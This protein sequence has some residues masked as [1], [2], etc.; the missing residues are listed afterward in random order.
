MPGSKRSL[1]QRFDPNPRRA[2]PCGLA[3]L[4]EGFAIPRGRGLPSLGNQ[5]EPEPV[6]G[7][8]RPYSRGASG[9]AIAHMANPER[10]LKALKADISA[11][12]TVGPTASRRKLWSELAGKAGYIDP[13]SL[14]P[15][16][17]FKVMG[18]LKLAGFRSAQLYLDAAK[19]QHIALGHQWTAQ[20]QQAYRSSVRSCARHIGAP[21]QASPLPLLQLAAFKEKE[22]I[23]KGGPL[24][25]GRSTILA[26]WWLLREIEASHATVD[27]ILVEEEL[28]RISWRLPCSKTDWK[29]L[30]AVRQHSCSCEFA[31]PGI[32]PYH[33]M[34]DHLKDIG[35]GRGDTLFPSEGGAPATKQGWADTFQELAV[36]LN[37]DPLHANGARRFT[38]HSARATGAVH[39]ASTQVELWRVQLFGRWG[40]EVFLHYIRDAPV[41]QLDKLALETSVHLSLESAKKQLQDLLRKKERD[42]KSVVA[43]PTPDMMVDCEAAA[44]HIDPPRQS[45]LAVRNLN[46]GK[47]KFIELSHMGKISTQKSGEHGVRGISATPTP[48]TSSSRS[49]KMDTSAARNASPSSNFDPMTPN[50]FRHLRMSRTPPQTPPPNNPLRRWAKFGIGWGSGCKGDRKLCSTM[51]VQVKLG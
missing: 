43:C 28:K 37:L 47:K 1:A 8:L 51:G 46:G 26:S 42:L 40:S 23:A 27:H 7:G 32:C 39:L 3:P 10:C 33:C 19:S 9:E 36:R 34:V 44:L 18:A 31:A 16:L 30:G 2:A 22:P 48:A 25:P 12:T 17:I 21:K 29:A 41:C 50:P 38:G 11:S 24:W 45:D 6:G 20:L 4:R 14:E 35:G 15:D 5:R 13:F 49:Q